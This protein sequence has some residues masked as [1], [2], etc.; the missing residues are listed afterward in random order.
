MKYLSYVWFFAFSVLTLTSCS[1]ESV[2][3]L[4]TANL[5]TKV[6][7]VHYTSIELEILDRVNDYRDQNGLPQLASLDEGSR[8]AA[9]HNDH[10]IESEEV[11]HDDFAY[12]YTALVNAE[13][14]KAV[15]ENVAFGYSSAEAVVKAWIASD[16][17]RE[18]M[19]GDHTH[20]GISVKEGKDSRL[21]FTNIFVR[22]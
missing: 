19:L 11:C 13:K 7:P 12:R 8:Q 6:S 14:A 4:E 22:K 9:Y 5:T 10:M 1:K 16:G 20:F 3:E 2:D 17:H 21:Y 15:S 18:N